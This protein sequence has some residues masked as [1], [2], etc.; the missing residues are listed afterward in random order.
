MNVIR[1]ILKIDL[2]VRLLLLAVLL[3]SIVPVTGEGRAIARMIS[4]AG[5]FVL[6]LLNGLRLPRK[7]VAAGLRNARFLAP[8]TLWSFGAMGL[9][10]IVLWQIAL[11]GRS[12]RSGIGPFVSR[13]FAKHS[14]I[15]NRLLLNCRRKCRDFC[16]CRRL[17]QYVGR[18]CDSGTVLSGRGE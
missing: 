4:E 17:A 15:G 11:G 6:F 5:I 3:A 12:T 10:G 18:I 14:S 8:L 13:I 16:G 2:L 7:D 9:V 1:T